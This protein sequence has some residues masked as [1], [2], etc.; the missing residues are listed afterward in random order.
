[1]SKRSYY[2]SDIDVNLKMKKEKFVEKTVSDFKYKS[3]YMGDVLNLDRAV[4][5]ASCKNVGTAAISAADRS[6][7]RS[8]TY[9]GH[10]I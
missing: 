9:S 6:S 7:S 8:M 5:A 3:N 10:T 4:T 1:M 2:V